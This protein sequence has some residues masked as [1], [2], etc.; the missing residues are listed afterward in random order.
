MLAIK[1]IGIITVSGFLAEVGEVGRFDDGRQ[2][3]RL[4][5]LSLRECSSGKH[6]GETAI[7]RRGRSRKISEAK[8]EQ[9]RQ[10]MNEIN[11]G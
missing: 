4:A 3:Q 11:A 10:M 6:K 8:R 1:G 2:I 7:S 9:A 5:G